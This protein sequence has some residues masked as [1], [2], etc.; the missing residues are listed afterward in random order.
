MWAISFIL[1]V[2]PVV[3]GGPLTFPSHPS[4]RHVTLTAQDSQPLV[5]TI[6]PT[7]TRTSTTTLAEPPTLAAG[8]RPRR[9]GRPRDDELEL[10]A[11]FAPTESSGS[12]ASS[13]TASTSS[14]SED[15]DSDSA[16][17]SSEKSETETETSG[18]HNAAAAQTTPAPPA[19]DPEVAAALAEQGYSQATYY[20][21]LTRDVT[22][23]HCGWHVPVVKIS[24]AAKEGGRKHS[25]KV[26]FLG[27]ACAIA[28]GDFLFGS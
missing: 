13:S 1:L 27:A 8:S 20:T 23:T 18:E 4:R 7:I 11:I 9:T 6:A 19:N 25:I 12:A 3:L 15:S 26:A 21:C 24:A 10:L 16:S 14:P 22:Y 5:P 2:L 28:I 17:V